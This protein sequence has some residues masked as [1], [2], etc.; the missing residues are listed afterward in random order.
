MKTK[1]EPKEELVI[2]KL[3][4]QDTKDA[5]LTKANKPEMIAIRKALLTLGINESIRFPIP[6]SKNANSY[7]LVSKKTCLRTA[8]TKIQKDLNIA[9]STTIIGHIAIIKRI[10]KN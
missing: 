9:V 10:S 4:E 6:G 3:S 7:E 5:L 8:L 2:E 1:K